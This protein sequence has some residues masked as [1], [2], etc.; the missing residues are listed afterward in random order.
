MTYLCK[1]A[2]LHDIEMEHIFKSEFSFA[3]VSTVFLVKNAVNA[4]AGLRW[5]NFHPK[6]SF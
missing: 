4:A 3:V 5:L 6:T 1:L 2:L